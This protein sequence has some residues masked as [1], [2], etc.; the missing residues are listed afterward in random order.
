[1]KNNISRMLNYSRV[2]HWNVKRVQQFC[3]DGLSKLE[4]YHRIYKFRFHF[5]ESLI[6]EIV[7]GFDFLNHLLLVSGILLI[8]NE[9]RTK[10]EN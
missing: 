4:W 7:E 2:E 1:M 5:R 9:I 3:S 8:I 6:R 10:F